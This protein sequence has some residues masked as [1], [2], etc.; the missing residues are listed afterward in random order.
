L[1]LSAT[2]GLD[3]LDPIAALYSM[4]L[5]AAAG[6]D[7]KIDFDRN[8]ATA[9]TQLINEFRHRQLIR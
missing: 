1:R 2:Y 9:K 8:T 4:L 5:V 3:D 6:N 7:F